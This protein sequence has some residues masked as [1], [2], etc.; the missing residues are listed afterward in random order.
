M[1]LFRV[2][3]MVAAVGFCLPVFYGFILYFSLLGFL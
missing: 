1:L 3:V 2:L